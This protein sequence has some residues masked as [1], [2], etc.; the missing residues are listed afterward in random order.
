[1]WD[2]RY[3]KVGDKVSLTYNDKPRSG[4]VVKVTPDYLTM[5]IGETF[6]SFHYDK[7]HDVEITAMADDNRE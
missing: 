2:F 5:A 6:R 4:E 3:F 7:M 1:M